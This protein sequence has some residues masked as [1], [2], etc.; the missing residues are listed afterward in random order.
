MTL[1]SE[2]DLFERNAQNRPADLA[3]LPLDPYRSSFTVDCS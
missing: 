3:K 2:V 1:M